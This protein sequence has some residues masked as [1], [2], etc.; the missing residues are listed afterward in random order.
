[1]ADERNIIVRGL[2]PPGVTVTRDIPFW[3]DEH[4][5]ADANGRWSFAVSL[6]PGENLL[7]FRIGSDTATSR[8]IT[9]HYQPD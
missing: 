7:T 6:R 5:V 4:T 8:T 3:F 9:V 2:A 1:V